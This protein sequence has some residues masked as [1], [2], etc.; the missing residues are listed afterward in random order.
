LTEKADFVIGNPLG[1]YA[2]PAS[3]EVIG[4]TT[5]TAVF[6]DYYPLE[7]GDSQ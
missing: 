7:F 5:D 2:L 3:D 1:R 6:G 4:E